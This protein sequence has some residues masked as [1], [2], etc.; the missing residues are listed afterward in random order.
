MRT[1]KE[2][3]RFVDAGGTTLH[4]ADG[5]WDLNINLLVRELPKDSFVIAENGCGDYLF[6]KTKNGKP[7]EKVFV[8]WHEENRSEEFAKD[9]GTLVKGVPVEEPKRGGEV[10]KPISLKEVERALQ[11]KKAGSLAGSEALKRLKGGSFG[12]DALPLLRKCLVGDDVLVTTEAIECIAKLGPAAREEGGDD[13]EFELFVV[14]SKV[15]RYSLYANCYSAALE[16]LQK[17]GGDEDLILNFVEHNVGLEN[18]DDLIASLQALREIGG[19]EAKDLMK[20]AAAFWM[21]K[22]NL[23]YKKEVEKLLA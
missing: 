1:P 10:A 6:L 20:R 11:D 19:K 9:L 7:G 4:C 5:D 13:L 22:L 8:Y 23:R 3:E 16:A 17:I 14:G 21:P 12:V 15:W 18:P 2:L